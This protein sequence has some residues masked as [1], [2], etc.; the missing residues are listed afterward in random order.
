MT[1]DV[2]PPV[3]LAGDGSL[4]KGGVPYRGFGINFFSAFSRTLEDPNDTTYREG[5]VELATR[6]IPFVRF[7]ACGFW[8][9]DWQ[10]YLEDREEYFKRLDDVVR[11]AEETGIGLIPSLFWYPASVSDVVGEPRNRWGD[12]ASKTHQF[13]RDYVREIVTRYRGSPAIW[14]WEFGNEFSL[15]CDLPNAPEHRPKVVPQLGA[16]G[17]RSEKDDLTH[18]M[19]ATAVRAFAEEVRKYDPVRPIAA[20]H[21]LPRPSA[22]HQR[23][24]RTWVSDSREEFQKNLIESNPDP[25]NV[26]SIHVY[27][28][29]RKNR[30]GQEDTSYLELLN[31]T[32]EACKEA[33]KALFVG[34]F[35]PEGSDPVQDRRELDRQIAAIELSEVPLAALWVYDLPNQEEKHSITPTN[36]RRYMLDLLSNANRRTAYFLH[37]RNPHKADLR[38]GG[39]LGRLLDNTVNRNRSGNGFNPVYYHLF[40]DQNLYRDDAVGFY[41]EHIFNGV[42]ADN[43]NSFFSP[44]RD[45]HYL[46][47]HSASSVSLIHPAR[48]S[49]W[50]VESELRYTFAGEGAVDVEFEAT[51]T[52]N[53]FP[54][55]YCAFMWACYMNRTREREYH[56]YGK[57]GDKEGWISFGEDTEDGFE[58]GT[59][60]FDG[61]PNLSYEEGARTLNV[62]ENPTKKFLLPFYYGLV[63]GDGDLG[64]TDDTMAAILMFDQTEPIRFALWNFIRDA[65]GNP[66]PHS[67]AWDWQYVIRSPVIGKKCGYRARM[68]YKPFV[69]PED[70]KDEYEKWSRGLEKGD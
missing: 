48:G 42:T 34:E 46:K 14:I 61:V 24:E 21:S 6:N 54:L 39:F 2:D 23:Y 37:S 65:S 58:T 29:A 18:D 57:D 35:G 59:V 50:G 17:P 16:N 47:Q 22:E 26:V 15:D 60:A 12:T 28:H 63:D 68:L 70:V 19:V 62:I 45:P 56:F 31:P 51:L 10:L 52:E 11:A 8:P 40:P 20:G 32:Q 4:L 9:V 43:E 55:G 1:Q 7:M 33:S 27:P 53:R 49:T 13:M 30:F 36:A 67:P 25:N 66:D 44:N 41:F 38:S 64:T 3:S 69:G 5:F